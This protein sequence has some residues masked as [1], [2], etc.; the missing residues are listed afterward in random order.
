MKL[1]T[2]CGINISYN[3]IVDKMI[4]KK[5]RNAKMFINSTDVESGERDEHC[6]QE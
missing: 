3:I 5:M 2:Q 6:W 1:E 4:K